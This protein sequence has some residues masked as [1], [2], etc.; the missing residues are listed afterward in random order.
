MQ[1]LVS[2]YI[3]ILEQIRFFDNNTTTS[4]KDIIIDNLEK[5]YPNWFYSWKGNDIGIELNTKRGHS[6][7]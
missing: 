2:T 6:V 4:E 1:L 5:N 3:K 7:Y